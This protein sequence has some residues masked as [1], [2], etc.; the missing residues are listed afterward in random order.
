MLMLL[1]AV[2]LGGP[3]DPALTEARAEVYLSLKHYVDD[4]TATHLLQRLDAEAE[5]TA[6]ELSRV[7][8]A[9]AQHVRL[10][11]YKRVAENLAAKVVS[12]ELG[13]PLP[14]SED[15]L[16]RTV[17]DY[18]GF[19]LRSYVTSG[20]SPKRWFGYFDLKHDTAQREW[21]LRQTVRC[22]TEAIN[23]W[24]EDKGRPL[25]VDEAE[26]ALTFIAE[27]G[28]IL[29]REDQDRMDKLHPVFDVGLDDVAKGTADLGGLLERLDAAC[30]TDVGGLV[31][32]TEPG[33][34]PVHN[35]GRLSSH[36]GQWGWL[37]RYA[38]FEEGIVGTA[39]MWA[40]EKEIAARKL[41]ADGGGDLYTRDRTDQFII[42]SLVYN[43]GILHSASTHRRIRDF[44]AGDYLYERSEANAHRRPRLNLDRP[45]VLLAEL[46]RG[47]SYRDQWTS[48]M[49]VYHVLQRY[50][51]WEALR[52]YT[53]VFDEHGRFTEAARPEP[54]APPEPPPPPEPEPQAPE[55]SGWGCVHAP[56]GASWVLIWLLPVYARRS[57][58]EKRHGPPRDRGS[59]R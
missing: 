36:D 53:D 8:A 51:A 47:A 56:L 10:I 27:G 31:V 43:S 29:L 21:D 25:R 24:A 20:V 41:A 39:L 34:Q 28:A 59:D 44:S 49:A 45:P 4:D 58:R 16:A 32:Y 22:S 40:W 9:P 7:G 46:F 23:A 2:A 11:L 13:P 19:K 6:G 33:M 1:A 12:D 14:M 38:T 3:P 15:Q 17:I 50:G 57:N 37:V 52:R 55:S 42:G 26:I 18:E 48:W 30:G 5:T 54:P 35:L